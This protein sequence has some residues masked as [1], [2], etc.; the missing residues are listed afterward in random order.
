M[1]PGITVLIV[2]GVLNLLTSF[3]SP[4]V[5]AGAI[6]IKNISHSECCGSK[7]DVRD[8]HDELDLSNIKPM[9]LNQEQLSIALKRMSEQK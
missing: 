1:D 7:L 3:L 8:H 5:I 4:L 9:Q 2:L 6:L